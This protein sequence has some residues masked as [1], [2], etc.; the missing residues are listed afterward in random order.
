MFM[1]HMSNHLNAKIMQHSSSVE[2]S[3]LFHMFNP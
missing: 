2:E 3:C 1:C